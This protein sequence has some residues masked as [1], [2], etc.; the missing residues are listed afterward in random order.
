MKSQLFTR[1][2]VHGPHFLNILMLKTGT[3]DVH[4][5]GEEHSNEGGC[6]S[7]T[8]IVDEIKRVID[9]GKAYLYLEMGIHYESDPG[10]HTCHSKP[11]SGV[12]YDLLNDLR[13]CMLAKRRQCK[14]NERLIRFTDVRECAGELPY[15]EDEKIF[16]KNA[17]RMC[18]EGNTEKAKQLTLD[19][20]VRPLE[21][22]QYAKAVPDP[23]FVNI[24]QTG[25]KTPV[26]KCVY[27]WWRDLVTVKC[28][29]AQQAMKQKD[30]LSKV[31][32]LYQEAMDDTMN[33]YTI[34]S[35]F[36]DMVCEDVHRDVVFYGGSAHSKQLVDFLLQMEFELTH[37]Q[38]NDLDNSCVCTLPKR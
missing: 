31:V 18:H 26:D 34:H 19:R 1:K 14:L 7:E 29:Q 24:V 9:E 22:M 32:K 3:H 23:E 15:T 36:R 5:F 4:V 21:L 11:P 8:D 37:S 16:V 33:V 30:F 25:G 38:D 20:F 10:H 12:R 27:Y 6:P 17:H 35:I 13:S 28:E 2:A